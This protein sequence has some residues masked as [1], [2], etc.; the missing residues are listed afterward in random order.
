[1]AKR[2]KEADA[3]PELRISEGP[4]SSPKGEDEDELPGN[5][6]EIRYP[7]IVALA[8]E[9]GTAIELIEFFDCI[10]GAM[11]SRHHYVGS[12]LV[13]S[14]RNVGH[15][16]DTSSARESRIWICRGRPSLPGFV[17]QKSAITRLPSPISGLAEE[18]WAL[19]PADPMQGVSYAT[20]PIL[21]E[22]AERQVQRSG[23]PGCRGS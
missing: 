5:P 20:R 7:G 4:E 2:R 6:Y 21:R 9:N 18:G 10:G 16:S 14:A 12:P 22:G 19:L 8:D 13:R 3:C 15:Q 23:S 17:E 11:W 1:M